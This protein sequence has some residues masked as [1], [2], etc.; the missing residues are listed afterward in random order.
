M[1][2][3]L[4]YRLIEL[5]SESY[6]P[7]NVA[8]ILSTDIEK[9]RNAGGEFIGEFIIG[10]FAFL[11]AIIISFILCW[12]MTL[13][14][15]VLIPITIFTQTDDVRKTRGRPSS[16]SLY[17]SDLLKRD[18]MLLSESCVNWMTTQ[19]LNGEEFLIK[20][21]KEILDSYDNTMC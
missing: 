17:K 21:Y 8:G 4:K 2:S 9:V 11:V 18:F 1:D 6:S 5:E 3:L 16:N 7:G 20:K 10:V 13:A 15:M 12:Q 14:V 19:S